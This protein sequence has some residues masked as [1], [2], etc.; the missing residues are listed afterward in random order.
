[1]AVNEQRRT[2]T[3]LQK[4][5]D[6]VLVALA[7]ITVAARVAG[8]EYHLSFSQFLAIRLR[9]VNL[10]LIFMVFLI[11]HLVFAACGLYRSRRLS[12]Q[13]T[14]V[15]DVCKATTI[16]IGL[17]MALSTAFSVHLGTD[18]VLVGFWVV[19][20]LYCV[21]GRMAVRRM[22]RGLRKRGKDLRHLLILGTNKR[23]VEFAR[24]IT[25]SEERGYRIVGFVDNY[26]SGIDAIQNSGY[27]VVSDYN[28]LAEYLRKNIVDEVAIFSPLG[29]YYA[30]SAKVAALCQQH[31]ILMRVN[32]DIFGLRILRWQAEEFNGDYYITTYAGVSEFLPQIAKRALDIAV[33]VL[34]LTALLP[35]MGLAA[36]A[37]KLT[38][39]GPVF[40]M[41]ERIGLNKRRFK[42]FKFRTMVVDAEKLITKLEANNEI[43]GPAFKMKD[44]PRITPVGRFLRKSSI[45]ELPQLLNVIEGSMSLVGPRPLPERDFEGFNEDWQRRR[46]SIK[47]GITCL[48]QIGGRSNVSFLEWMKLDLKY[49]DEWS[50]WL[51][52]KI[53]LKT[54][55][56]V[57]WGR[58]AA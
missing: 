23:A 33:S 34:A 38:S 18:K 30:H 14:E 39:P 51:D 7:L 15:F 20:T 37:I 25:A 26:W 28:G 4:V 16:Y 5:F 52:L 21:A 32:S 42:I 48:W 54:V 9:V 1:M 8:H 41:Q 24:K 53:L 57:L 12:R 40:F 47:P 49:V 19:C 45:D 29:S 44:D 22:A 56:A 3:Q 46:F 35:I 13:R 17:M 31:G 10:F 11:A 27:K 43:D 50:F 55:P 36:L 58:G 6:M 2:V